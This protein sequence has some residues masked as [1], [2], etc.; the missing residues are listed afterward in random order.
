MTTNTTTN[1]IDALLRAQSRDTLALF[2]EQRQAIESA[3]ST[4]ELI[5]ADARRALD[6]AK[7]DLDDQIVRLTPD[8]QHPDRFA[9]E[10]AMLQSK[11][12]DVIEQE[13]EID[14]SVW[15]DTEPLRREE[16][17]N[18][19]ELSRAEREQDRNDAL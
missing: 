10:R 16:R 17:D 6:R 11:R 7:A 3:I 19:K 15:R 5:G 2:R 12:V 4:R 1:D 9:R 8:E 18:E 13:G 14:T